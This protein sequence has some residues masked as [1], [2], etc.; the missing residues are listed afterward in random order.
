MFKLPGS[1]LLLV[2]VDRMSDKPFHW[3]N[4]NKTSAEQSKRADS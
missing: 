2:M 3:G 1:F 4:K